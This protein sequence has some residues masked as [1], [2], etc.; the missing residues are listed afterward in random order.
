MSSGE[1][2]HLEIRSECLVRLNEVG[3]HIVIL[4]EQLYRKFSIYNNVGNKKSEETI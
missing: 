1:E 2:A 4:I 3:S